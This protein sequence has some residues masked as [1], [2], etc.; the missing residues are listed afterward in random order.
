MLHCKF[1]GKE[2]LL[3]DCLIE[4]VLSNTVLIACMFIIHFF[5][6]SF[7]FDFAKNITRFA[8]LIVRV[9]KALL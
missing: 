4:M 9:F 6:F 8:F 7:P 1:E 2:S 5:L 3:I